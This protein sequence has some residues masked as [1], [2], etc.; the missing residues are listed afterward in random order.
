M[1]SFAGDQGSYVLPTIVHASGGVGYGL[2]SKHKFAVALIEAGGR[3]Y[4][5]VKPR[6]STLLRRDTEALLGGFLLLEV[7]VCGRGGGRP[8]AGILVD[9]LDG[10]VVNEVGGTGLGVEPYGPG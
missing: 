4:C 3:G 7:G 6:R 8:G 5:P 9:Q 1:K 2:E 10:R